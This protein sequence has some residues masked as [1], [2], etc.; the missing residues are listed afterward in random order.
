[1]PE[2]AADPR[3]ATRRRLLVALIAAATLAGGMGLLGATAA[4]ATD[5]S[6][7]RSAK[8]SHSR[9]GGHDCDRQGHVGEV[10]V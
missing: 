6:A 1:M 9:S 3:P 5:G 8:S 10:S 2:E 7:G 4:R